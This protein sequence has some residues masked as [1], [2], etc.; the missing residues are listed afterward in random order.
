MERYFFTLRAGGAGYADPGGVRIRPILI[1]R[2]DE[3]PRHWRI[4][5][6]KADIV[7]GGTS[8]VTVVAALADLSSPVR[9]SIQTCAER[10]LSLSEAVADAHAL[11]RRSR[12]LIARSRGEPYLTVQNRDWE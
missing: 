1:V 4:D 10:C 7:I 12:A 2:V 6:T 8:F 3:E 9:K 11:C 5:V